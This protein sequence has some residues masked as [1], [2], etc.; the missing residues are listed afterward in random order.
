MGSGKAHEDSTVLDKTRE[1]V[2]RLTRHHAG[3]G[4]D[5]DRH[6]LIEKGA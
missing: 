5:H 4:E 3:I 2:M 6:M 1:V